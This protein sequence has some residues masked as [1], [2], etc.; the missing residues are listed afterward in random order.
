[1]HCPESDDDIECKLNALM[2]KNR[3]NR[4]RNENCIERSFS[5]SFHSA[6]VLRFSGVKYMIEKAIVATNKAKPGL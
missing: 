2:N 3:V 1:M 5:F 4:N 6:M